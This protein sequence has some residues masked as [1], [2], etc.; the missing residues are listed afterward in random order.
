MVVLGVGDADSSAV[1]AHS[2]RRPLPRRASGTILAL[3]VRLQKEKA[4]D[5]TTLAQ[6]IDLS[7]CQ[8]INTIHCLRFFDLIFRRHRYRSFTKSTASH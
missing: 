7:L 5:A 6:T 8:W 1:S 4:M 2:L 3:R